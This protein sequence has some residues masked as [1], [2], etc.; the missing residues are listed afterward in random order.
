[1]GYL[2][3]F[4][5][6]ISKRSQVVAHQLIWN[7]QTNMYVDEEMTTKDSKQQYTNTCQNTNFTIYVLLQEICMI[8]WIRYR[9]IS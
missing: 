6:Y 2:I 1:M 9:K 7:M 8:Y 3:E 4:I 5:K